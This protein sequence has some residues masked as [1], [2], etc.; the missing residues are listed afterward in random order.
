MDEKG[1]TLNSDSH[2]L[3]KQ[4]VSSCHHRETN[5]RKDHSVL[6]AQ[7]LAQKY[8]TTLD[9][10]AVSSLRQVCVKVNRYDM[11]L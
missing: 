11:M 7:N 6:G 3:S 9:L 1:Q 8:S 2:S 10:L 5:C 4:S